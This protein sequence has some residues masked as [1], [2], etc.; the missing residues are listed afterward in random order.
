MKKILAAIV[1]CIIL[2]VI[3]KFYL[4]YRYKKELDKALTGA[5]LVAEVVYKDLKVGFDG[6]IELL[7]L[8]VTPNGNFNTFSFRSI[9]ISGF[10]FLFHFNGKSRME[11]G[12]F[13]KFVNFSVDQFSF[14]ASVYEDQVGE[15]KRCRSLEGTLMYSFAGFDQVVANGNI[16]LDLADPFAAS[17]EFTGT[18]QIS[19]VGFAMNF[20]ARAAGPQALASGEIPVQSMRYDY[21]LDEEAAAEILAY[22]AKQFK[23]TPKVFLNKIVKTKKF[24]TNSFQL[25]LGEKASVALAEFL[26]GGKEVVIRSTPSDRLKNMNFASKSSPAQIVRMLNLN[27]SLDGTTVPIRTFKSRESDNIDDTLASAVDGAAESDIGDEGAA[28]KKPKPKASEKRDSIYAVAKLSNAGSYINRH[29]RISRTK[30]RAQIIGVLL[31]AKDQVL[32]IETYR[33]GGV[34]LYSIPYADV[35]K[36]EVKNL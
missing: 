23:V 22:C 21:A 34:L 12:D 3:G 20:N 15:K 7:G 8:S 9:K 35:S 11:K 5:S 2:V 30:D 17:L 13:P 10:D 24:M 18:D 14:P 33:F 6:A 36:V 16:A 29:V 27:V 28:K 31:E 4:E 32:S 26:Q 19:R 25:D 1:I